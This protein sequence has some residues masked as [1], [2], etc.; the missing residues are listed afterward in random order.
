MNV[1]K[2][3]K[4]WYA[5]SG[6]LILVSMISYAVWGL[7]LGI[8]FTGGSLAEYKVA[9][10][11][12]A[13]VQKIVSDA[14]IANA[15][16]VSTTN[17]MIV[18]MQEVNGDKHTAMVAGMKKA[19]KDTE[20]VRFESVGPSIGAELRSKAVTAVVI[21]LL[22]ICAYIA[23][24]FRKVTGR[25]QAW[26]YG[27]VTILIGLNDAI[28]PVGAFAIFGH[29]AGWEVN[30][31][32]VAAILTILGYSI[33]DTIVVFDRIRENLTKTEGTV[34]EIVEH[35]IHQTAVRSI[36]TSMTVV[37]SLLAIYLFG[38]DSTKSFAMALIIGVVAGT[39]SSIFLASPLLV[40][41]QK[42]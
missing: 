1:V 22:L 36:N 11:T 4:I 2:A 37:L 15:S 3:R 25:I 29:L 18:R 14:G 21:M 20:E 34:A 35:S 39:Y 9:G 6:T 7:K 13:E 24:A 33:N 23:Y 32:F 31:A 26:K 16:V 5:I 27:V 30:G 10:A 41:W 12:T 40:D 38:G 19:W 28:V 42:K 17:G 8:E